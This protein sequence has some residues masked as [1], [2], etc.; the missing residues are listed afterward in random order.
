MAFCLD[1]GVF[2][3]ASSCVVGPGGTVVLVLE[4]W[5]PERALVCL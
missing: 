3:G 2:L 5:G 4:V 1:V